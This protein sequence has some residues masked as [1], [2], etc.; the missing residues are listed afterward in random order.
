MAAYNL[1]VYFS[2]RDKL[3]ILPKTHYGC[4]LTR[5]DLRIT[6]VDSRKR[7]WNLAKDL[8]PDLHGVTPVNED[9]PPVLQHDDHARRPGETAD[10]AQ[11]LVAFG[12]VLAQVLVGAGD[13][14]GVQPQPGHLLAN[15]GQPLG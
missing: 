1:F 11:P 9:H 6:E 14:Q 15:P 13:D 5:I 10:P 8:L 3:V 12:N 4:D 7:V 2:L